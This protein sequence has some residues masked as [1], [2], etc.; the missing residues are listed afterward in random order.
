MID[1]NFIN[2]IGGNLIFNFSNESTNADIKLNNIKFTFDNCDNV[3]IKSNNSAKLNLN[4]SY[5][6]FKDCFNVS[7][8]NI[9]IS[10]I[11]I[12]NKSQNNILTDTSATY[13]GICI[14]YNSHFNCKNMSISRKYR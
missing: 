4:S 14:G 8:E 6:Q 11:N 12:N 3:L 1:Y 13:N 2:F 7:F 5:F 9:S 10:G